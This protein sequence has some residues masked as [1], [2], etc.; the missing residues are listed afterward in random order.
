MRTL[1]DAHVA[2]VYRISRFCGNARDK[3]NLGK[4]GFILSLSS[5]VEFIV[6]GKSWQQVLPCP[7]YTHFFLNHLN[8]TDLRLGMQ[9]VLALNFSP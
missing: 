8:Q 1:R 2:L 9:L 6:T 4:G 3:R 5:R 7:T